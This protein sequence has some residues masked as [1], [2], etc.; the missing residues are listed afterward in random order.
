[1]EL[2]W[3]LRHWPLDLV[4]EAEEVRGSLARWRG[5]YMNQLKS[6]NAAL[7]A[8]LAGLHSEVDRFV[9]LGD[10]KQVGGGGGVWI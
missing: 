5:R 7:V 2:F 3:R 4:S 6:D 8:D 1:M 9:M 10:L